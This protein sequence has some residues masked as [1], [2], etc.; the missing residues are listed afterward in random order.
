V[1]STRHHYHLAGALA[2]GL[3]A[4]SA[5]AHAGSGNVEFHI[6]RQSLPNA[7]AEF[8]R[9]SG[10]QILFPY[11]LL[12]DVKTRA[13]DGRMSPEQAVFAMVEGTGIKANHA[14]SRSFA[15]S[16]AK[17]ERRDAMPEVRP[18]ALLTGAATSYAVA[19]PS[20]PAPAP[21][22]ESADAA[23]PAT[24]V[25]TGTRGTPRT[26]T[27][28]PTPI[29][30]ISGNELER[31]GKPGVLAALNTLVPSF[32]M[33]TRAGGGTATVIS[34]GGLRGLNPDQMLVLVNGKR[35]HKTSLINAV[36][37]L[38]NGSVPTDLD[39]IPTSAVDHIEVLRDGA[40]AQ[41]GSDAIAGVINIIL[42]KEKNK[43]TASFTAGQNMDRSDGE[44]FLG[45][46]S[47]GVAL[48]DRGF[49]DFFVN[50]KKQNASNRARPISSSAA[51]YNT[52]NG[53]PDPREATADRLVTKNYGAFPTQAVNLGYN[54]SFQAGDIEVYS[55]GTYGLR[56]SELDFTF[57]YP[58]NS[59]SLP[60][61]YPNGFRPSLNVNE[62][63]FEFAL[64][65]KGNLKGWKWDLS[66]NY[67]KNRSWQDGYNTL[68]PSL[69]PTSPTS[70]YVGSLIST[71]WDNSLDLTKGYKVGGGNLQVSA[72]L[73]HRRETYAVQQGD[74]ASYAAGSYTYTVNGAVVR[75]AP[76]AQAAAGFTPSDAGYQ[77]RNNLSAY[78]GVTYDPSRHTTVDTAVRFEHFDDGSGNAVIGKAT[79]R[80]ELTPWLAL[81]GAVNNG[82]RAPSIAQQLY[83]STTGQFRTVN[84]V[85]DLLEI[86]TL[87]VGSPAAIALG[88]KPLKPERSLNF[89]AGFVLKPTHRL[90]ITVDAYQIQVNDRIAL[91]STLTGTAVSNI[92]VANGL[93]PDIS[94]QYYTNAINTRTRGIDVVATWHNTVANSVKMQWNLGYNYNQTIINGVAANPSQLAALG[95]NYVLFDRVSQMNMTDNLPKSK[96]FLNNIST[97]GNVSLST[98]LVRY[99]GFYSNQNSSGTVG[100]VAQYASDR[101]FGAKWITDMELSWQANKAIN[102][103]IGANNLFNVY[104][105]AVGVYSTTYGN[106]QYPSTGA[107]GFTGG[108]YYGRV[109][110]NF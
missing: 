9:Q 33:P 5:P 89:S 16:M 83:A 104:P 72:G 108:Y 34:T 81:R 48:G 73:M 20:A 36:S 51:L 32:N 24:I 62:Q 100:G 110:V 37:S 7:M 15:L 42:K 71:E 101:Y 35:R 12:K 14:G 41:Y 43:G 98:R 80:Q 90:N 68:N 1:G 10:F 39:M 64:G 57:R 86:K 26:V 63:D 59:A 78:L 30:V 75:P 22:G 19:Q 46:A 66:S 65:A 2:L 18:V 85:L 103:S 92:L 54:S 77:V 23:P 74:A 102:L 87:P 93:S 13:I 61:I 99:G 76:G 88:S 47:Y 91:T 27:D 45:E 38:Y 96:L 58:S 25:V 11:D 6:P 31:T 17:A 52:V 53:A 95:A 3:A 107:Y 8:S 84:G 29:D 50:A 55:F 79:I 70:F 69:G 60:Q 105:D 67:G 106:G 4:L 49:A 44:N 56:Q 28:S 40:A 97:I 21:R 94:A 109:R 82:F